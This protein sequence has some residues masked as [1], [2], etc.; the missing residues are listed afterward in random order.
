MS[1]G[2]S[3]LKSYFQEDTLAISNIHIDSFH[4][5]LNLLPQYLKTQIICTQH[6]KINYTFKF[7]N[8]K[9]Y[10]PQDEKGN[11]LYP[12][13]ARR[14]NKNY[15]SK[16]CCD[17]NIFKNNNQDNIL[18]NVVLCEIPIMIK[19]KYCHTHTIS[20]KECPYDKGGYFIIN[21]IERVIVSQLQYASNKI[22]VHQ[23]DEIISSHI[24]SCDETKTIKNFVRIS[25]IKSQFYIESTHLKKM[26]IMIFFIILCEL[27]NIKT[28]KINKI[29]KQVSNSF[30]IRFLEQ[31]SLSN[32]KCIKKICQQNK[33][34]KEEIKSH[35]EHFFPHIQLN[36]KIHDIF[37]FICVMLKKIHYTIIHKRKI[38]NKDHLKN[39]IIYTSGMLY[40]E[41]FKQGFKKYSNYI[42]T[43][44]SKKRFSQSFFE[45]HIIQQTMEYSFKTGN[46]ISNSRQPQVGI[47]QILNRVSYVSTLSHL[48]RIMIV[49]PPNVIQA[50]LIHLSQMG[51]ICPC[52]TPEGGKAGVVLNMALTTDVTQSL[53]TKKIYQ[54]IKSCISKEFLFDKCLIFLNGQII[55]STK[56]PRQLCKKLRHSSYLGYTNKNISISYDIMENEIHIYCNE[57]RLIRPILHRSV[58]DINESQIS[59]SNCLN[60]GKIKYMDTHEI[61]QQQIALSYDKLS[62][63]TQYMEIHPCVFL[64]VVA[65]IIPFIQ[66]NP[67]PRNC[68]SSS[69]M[70][71]S[72]GISTLNHT[73]RFDTRSD[74]LNYYQ[75]PLIQNDI[76]SLLHLDQLTHGMNV[77][78]AVMSYS[79]YNQE[80]SL[81][82]NQSAIERG[83][84]V[85]YTYKTICI[86]EEKNVYGKKNMI[87]NHIYPHLQNTSYNYS[88]LNR[89]G[90]IKKK[91]KIECNDVLVRMV[92][93]YDNNVYE[94]SIIAQNEH[95]GVIEDIVMFTENNIKQVKIK[96]RQQKIPE[97]GDKFASRAGQ[98]GTI[99]MVYRQ[100][101]MPFNQEGICPDIIINPNAF[102]SR[103]T[104][105]QLMEMLT[106]KACSLTGTYCQTSAFDSKNIIQY[107]CQQLQNNEFSKYNK[108]GWETL[109]NGFT[110]EPI[111]AR[112]FMGVAYY[113]K[114][115]HL[116]SE[117]IHYRTTGPYTQ[118]T[119]QPVHGR[120]NKGG[121]KMGE[122]ERDTLLS[123]GVSSFCKEMYL[124]NS[125]NFTVFMC[126]HCNQIRDYNFCIEC[127]QSTYNMKMPYATKLL[128]QELN[129]VG[130]KT[131]FNHSL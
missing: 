114:L 24:F 74:V 115:K 3:L 108:H 47:S 72:I 129:G 93:S 105:N 70:K 94:E 85:S 120:T 126:T 97:I 116:V 117:K 36:Y 131:H 80:D 26:N 8:I 124:S 69:M 103:M 98:K 76:S 50:K 49:D 79:G 31:L 75:K 112:V 42:Q 102:P 6:R 128:L 125:D 68:Y 30:Y 81:I 60:I 63:H 53:P 5:F 91:S 88:K 101:D 37:L 2:L 39:K 45:N 41:L 34:T 82:V 123:H 92:S 121:M 119:R 54:K 78:V 16:I 95:I 33:K 23:K 25:K 32:T 52:E 106:G 27:F 22:I 77:V 127:N 100:E 15:S 57:G 84:F 58:Y 56:T 109:Y 7:T 38:D 111:H 14:Y 130:I 122:M 55:G 110:G 65:N 43:F 12:H 89:Y 90:I 28:S 18:K 96:I 13:M 99:G 61:E 62:E 4:E 51:Y 21:G 17:I 1:K 44:C 48:R 10:K 87:G 104:I 40:R 64:G 86:C 11:P 9:I 59:W 83:L 35:I 20:N 71:Q 67:S 118:L 107:I 113:Q 46:W 29:L 66:H 73:N 19:S